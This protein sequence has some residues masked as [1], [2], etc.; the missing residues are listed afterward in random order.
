M[1]KYLEND[2]NWSNWKTISIDSKNCA[3]RSARQFNR[4]SHT[5]FRNLTL[6]VVTERM[7]KENTYNI[8]QN[9]NNSEL[10][11]T[12]PFRIKYRLQKNKSADVL[13]VTVRILTLL[14]KCFTCSRVWIGW[15]PMEEEHFEMAINLVF[16]F[17]LFYSGDSQNLVA[18]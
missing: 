6:V 13:H 3:I 5:H 18:V 14:R 4:I 2:S 11:G 8:P 10:R 1:G 12:F 15:Q 16:E 7:I 9:N 17:F